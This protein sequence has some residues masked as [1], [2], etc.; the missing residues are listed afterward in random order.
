MDGLLRPLHS[1]QISSSLSIARKPG[2]N[3]EPLFTISSTKSIQKPEVP[4]TKTQVA[5]PAFAEHTEHR[6]H[7]R[8]IASQDDVLQVLRSSPSLQ[9]LAT[10]LNYLV[11]SSETEGS[12]LTIH[13]PSPTSSQ[14]VKILV[15]CTIPDFW[16]I[17]CEDKSYT[18]EKD[19]LIACLRSVLGL[20]AIVARLSAL[21]A[22]IEDTGLSMTEKDGMLCNEL[23]E[24]MGIVLGKKSLLLEVWRQVFENEGGREGME[25][26]RVKKDILWKEFVSLVAGGK[27][28]G[29]A[30]GAVRVMG[31]AW[32]AKE[33][34]EGGTTDNGGERGAAWVGD[35][36]IYATWLGKA[37]GMMVGRLNSMNEKEASVGWDCLRALFWRSFGLGTAYGIVETATMDILLPTPRWSALTKLLVPSAAYDKSRYLHSIL[38]VLSKYYLDPSP[39]EGERWW[40]K[41]GQVIARVAA[42]IGGIVRS[43]PGFWNILREWILRPAGVGEPIGIRRAVLAALRQEGKE[44]K[45]VLEKSLKNFGDGLWIKHT[46]IQAQEVNIQIIL[47][48]AGYLHRGSPS[49]LKSVLQTSV[50][51]NSISN[52]LSAHSPRARFLGMIVGETL[53]E[54]AD[55]KG[56]KLD[57]KIP[58]MSSDEARRWK[59]LVEVVD[60]I[61]KVDGLGRFVGGAWRGSEGG[62]APRYKGARIVDLV[63]LGD[64]E[65][66]MDED[67]DEFKPYPKPDSD[68]ED[69]DDDDPTLVNKKKEPA[70]VYIRDLLRLLR[71]HDSYDKQRLALTHAAT[72]IRRKAVFG[73]ELAEHLHELASSLAGLQDKFDMENFQEMRTQA[74]IA[75]VIAQPVKMGQWLAQ[76]FF[77]GEYSI[78]QRAVLL[79]A[80]GLGAREVGGLRDQE[81]VWGAEVGKGLIGSSR[82]AKGNEDLFPSKMLPG[83]LH[84]IY[85]SDP[86]TQMQAQRKTGK[87]VT[88]RLDAVTS[89]LEKMMIRPM[90][91]D[92]ADKLSGPNVLKVRTFSSRMAVEKRRGKPEANKLAQVVGEGFFYPLTG[93]WWAKLREFGPNAPNFHPYLLTTLLKTLAL[94]LHA[95]GP[96]TPALPQLTTEFWDILLS[97]R[98]HQ[99]PAVGKSALNDTDAPPVLESI[100]FSLLT[101]LDLNIESGETGKRRLVEEH[102]KTLVETAEWVEGIFEGGFGLGGSGREEEKVRQLAAAVLLRVRDVMQGWER[103]LMGEMV[104]WE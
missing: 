10:I 42:V 49:V 26:T 65:D 33:E 27:V 58:E 84:D 101:L 98:H 71:A 57:F 15:D 6:G 29:V 1:G 48:T 46:P 92:A 18:K 31:A 38:R 62:E 24:A 103:R 41:D 36:A 69:S 47:L 7:P 99:H 54:L 89:D 78:G 12:H 75:L 9:E 22:A 32:G 56:I 34:A 73:T 96:S 4:K 95:A 81:V 94:I 86:K 72:L 60:T 68:S 3:E 8:P 5:N 93:R 100:L 70:P 50:Y 21:T 59:S 91:A 17:I 88:G 23:L 16:H 74:L 44:M 83:K 55:D 13:H 11:T 102:A 39:A 52:R 64:G 87:L 30:A 66:G 90:A 79:S 63:E 40:E 61:G 82:G 20:G 67:D 53:S 14:I 19:A 28:L 104:R 80:M 35:E 97:L 37:V 25:I 51:L 77:D 2:D 45:Y 76:A 43:D 85:S